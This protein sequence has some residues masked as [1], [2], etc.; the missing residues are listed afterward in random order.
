[1]HVPPPCHI[2]MGPSASS[3]GPSIPFWIH[4]WFGR[5]SLI[6]TCI[7]CTQ[8]VWLSAYKDITRRHEVEGVSITNS[9]NTLI[10]GKV[11]GPGSQGPSS[12]PDAPGT[13]AAGAGPATDDGSSGAAGLPLRLV[14]HLLYGLVRLHRRQVELLHQVRRGGTWSGWYDGVQGWQAR[15]AALWAACNNCCMG[16]HRFTAALEI[17]KSHSLMPC[18]C[19]FRTLKPP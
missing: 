15:A 18:P 13:S 19:Y 3:Y 5:G 17:C 9:A 8:M 16:H 12:D 7:C 6:L 14:A 2:C 1:M 10:S 11:A 4:G